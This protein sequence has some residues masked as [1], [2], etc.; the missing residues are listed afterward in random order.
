MGFASSQDQLAATGAE[1]RSDD[2]NL[3]WLDLMVQLTIFDRMV[4]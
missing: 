2:P 3:G 1:I 4:V